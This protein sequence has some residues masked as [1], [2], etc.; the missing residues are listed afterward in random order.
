M[1][2]K[3]YQIFIVTNYMKFVKTS[4]SDS[5]YCSVD[6]CIYYRSK[7]INNDSLFYNRYL[8]L[9]TLKF[10]IGK[11]ILYRIFF[12][13]SYGINEGVSTNQKSRISG[14]L[15]DFIPSVMAISIIEIQLFCFIPE[16]IRETIFKD[17]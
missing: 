1:L 15:F 17:K 4:W 8:R 9:D 5:K 16:K 6:L 12:Q 10:I 13:F 7:L 2:K 3:S 11:Y 14:V